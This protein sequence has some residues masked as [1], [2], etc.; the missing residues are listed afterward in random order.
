[1]YE[2]AGLS[3]LER[4]IGREVCSVCFVRDYIEIVFEEL[5]LTCYTAPAILSSD[6]DQPDTIGAPGYRDK[7]C[8]FIG[9]H[10]Q[11]VVEKPLEISVQFDDGDGFTISLRCEDAVGPEAALL[12]EPGAGVITV[13]QCE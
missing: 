9:K 13:W 2:K 7:L 12:H 11:S 1:M 8:E 6:S 4:L 5:T 3:S 10:I